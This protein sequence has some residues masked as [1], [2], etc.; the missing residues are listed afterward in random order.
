MNSLLRPLNTTQRETMK[1]LLEG[2]A[3]D[4]LEESF[5][6][7]VPTILENSTRKKERK[8]LNE[9]SSKEEKPVLSEST[10]DRSKMNYQPTTVAQQN[11]EEDYSEIFRLAGVK[12]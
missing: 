12:R 4:K 6:R 3:T 10:G 5:K 7:Y 11:Q 1:A 9:Q 2:V 8:S